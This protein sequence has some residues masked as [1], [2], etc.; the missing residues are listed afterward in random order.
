M[1]KWAEIPIHEFAKRFT[2]PFLRE[3][4]LLLFDLPDSP[5]DRCVTGPGLQAPEGGRLSN[6]RIAGVLSIYRTTLRSLGSQNSIPLFPSRVQASL[7]VTR[8]FEAVPHS[9]IHRLEEP[10]ILAVE[11]R[12]ALSVGIYNFDPTL[13]PQGKTV[14]KVAFA[15]DSGRRWSRLLNAVGRRKRRSPIKDLSARQAF[16]RAWPTKWACARRRHL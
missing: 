15:S 10:V 14:V 7:R 11:E 6:R 4:L 8:C 16:P 9:I 2:N 3:A 12:E 1:R 5:H 13:A